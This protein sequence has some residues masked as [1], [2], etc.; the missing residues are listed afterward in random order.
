ML[1]IPEQVGLSSMPWMG[2]PKLRVE[3]GSRGTP[4]L[5]MLVDGLLLEPSL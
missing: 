1:F 4:D 5:L 3:R 2:T